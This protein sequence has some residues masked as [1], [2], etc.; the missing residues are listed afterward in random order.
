MS[1]NENDIINPNPRFDPSIA[2]LEIPV[3]I[4]DKVIKFISTLTEE[5]VKEKNSPFSHDDSGCFFVISL[6]QIEEMLNILN[7]SVSS[8]P[9]NADHAQNEIKKVISMLNG[10]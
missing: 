2:F 3:N 1:L 9:D 7:G 8:L 10:Q 5:D 6:E 4:K